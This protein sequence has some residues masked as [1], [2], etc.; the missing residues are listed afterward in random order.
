MSLKTLI[1]NGFSLSSKSN[2][3]NQ[4]TAGLINI[5]PHKF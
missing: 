3:I 2:D 1:K 4:R 5:D